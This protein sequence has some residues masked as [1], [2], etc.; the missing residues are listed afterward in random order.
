MWEGLEICTKRFYGIGEIDFGVRLSYKME[1][2]HW[3][4]YLLFPLCIT[5]RKWPSVARKAISPWR[6]KKRNEIWIVETL[7][8]GQE[9]CQTIIKREG[10]GRPRMVPDNTQTDKRGLAQC[11]ELGAPVLGVPLRKRSFLVLYLK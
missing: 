6:L 9:K 3:G 1:F 2:L 7:V 4:F 8:G 10:K 11:I 5:G